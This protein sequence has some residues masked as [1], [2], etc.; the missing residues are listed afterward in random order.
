MRIYLKMRLFSKI[1]LL[2]LICHAAFAEDIKTGL[3]GWW[4]LDDGSGTTAA[5]ISGQG[6][7][8]TLTGGP[9]WASNCKRTG[10]VTFDGTLSLR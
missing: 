5:D 3:I 4:K 6:N 2:M 9:K 8:G 1:I 10:C 7:T